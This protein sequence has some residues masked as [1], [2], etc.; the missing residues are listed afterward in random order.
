MSPS[1]IAFEALTSRADQPE[2]VDRKLAGRWVRIAVDFPV[3]SAQWVSI[4]STPGH[5]GLVRMPNLRDGPVM[6]RPR[7]HPTG[8]AGGVYVSAAFEWPIDLHANFQI[9]NVVFVEHDVVSVRI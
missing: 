7:D 4:C 1:A 8:K 3:L 2:D 6:P 9:G 5:D